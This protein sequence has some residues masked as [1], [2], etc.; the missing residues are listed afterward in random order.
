L[1]RDTDRST[2]SLKQ[3]DYIDWLYFWWWLWL[4]DGI[5]PWMQP[6]NRGSFSELGPFKRWPKIVIAIQ[7]MRGQGCDGAANEY[8]GFDR[9][10]RFKKPKIHFVSILLLS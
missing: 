7:S 5:I 4:F 2:A 3:Q 8:N 10:G 1:T 6:N 9:I